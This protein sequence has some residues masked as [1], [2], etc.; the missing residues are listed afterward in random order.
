[1]S[2]KKSEIKRLQKLICA[3]ATLAYSGKLPRGRT[4]WGD[5]QWFRIQHLKELGGVVPRSVPFN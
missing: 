3:E 1:M 5:A 4:N 2:D